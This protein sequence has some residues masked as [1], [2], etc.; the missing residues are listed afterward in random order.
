MK[1]SDLLF[2]K[3]GSKGKIVNYRENNL[4]VSMGFPFHQQQPTVRK[5]S[6]RVGSAQGWCAAWMCPIPRP[7]GLCFLFPESDLGKG[8][9][10]W[11]FWCSVFP[12][13]RGLLRG[14]VDSSVATDWGVS[15]G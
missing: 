1:L 15:V 8:Q 6:Q 5:G 2:Y 12:G 3:G 9:T 14:Y 11:R 4:P 7:P 13:L 10:N